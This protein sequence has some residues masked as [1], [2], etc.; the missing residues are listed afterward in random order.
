MINYLNFDYNLNNQ[1]FLLQNSPGSN[2]SV[3][4]ESLIQNTK[5]TL[6]N[7]LVAVTVI[8][9][10]IQLVHFKTNCRKIDRYFYQNHRCF[11]SALVIQPEAN[12]FKN[13]T[14][15]FMKFPLLFKK[16]T[17]DHKIPWQLQR[18]FLLTNSKSNSP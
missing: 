3:H 7:I 14:Y 10:S 11:P 1:F 17:T 5:M 2:V 13:D 15:I 18:R 4:A 12:S 9:I 6:F 8:N 16:S